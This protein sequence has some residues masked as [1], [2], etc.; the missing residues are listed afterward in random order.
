MV[1][2]LLRDLQKESLV[3]ESRPSL[4]AA[5]RVLRGQLDGKLPWYVGL[6]DLVIWKANSVGGARRRLGA[7][8]KPIVAQGGK[9]DER[10]QQE[11]GKG[12]RGPA[13]H[14]GPQQRDCE[15]AGRDREA[16]VAACA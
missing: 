3:A 1:L 7:L 16:E 9:V 13:D 15:A 8:H 11:Q 6:F 2:Q 14:R 5:G 4:A 12:S 10:Y